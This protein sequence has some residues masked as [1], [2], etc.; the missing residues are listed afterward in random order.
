LG[1]GVSKRLA[2]LGATVILWDVNE[3]GNDDTKQQILNERADAQVHAMKVNLCD[4]ADIYRAAEEV[5]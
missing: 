5:R 4:R 1:R 3:K 2:A